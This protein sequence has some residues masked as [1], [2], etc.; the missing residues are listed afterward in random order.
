MTSKKIRIGIIGAGNIAQNAHIPAY[1]K[2]EDVELI[3]V[4][5]QNIQRAL[6]VKKKHNYINRNSGEC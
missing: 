3:G 5:D 4:C 2:N 6:D 1:L